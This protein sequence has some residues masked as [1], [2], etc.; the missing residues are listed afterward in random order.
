MKHNQGIVAEFKYQDKDLGKEAECQNNALEEFKPRLHKRQC[1][2]CS[3]KCN[4]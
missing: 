4:K 2:Q 1:R 3:K